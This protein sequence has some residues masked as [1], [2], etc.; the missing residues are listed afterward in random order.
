MPTRKVVVQGTEIQR[1]E[2]SV[3][4]FSALDPGFLTN[5]GGPFV[6]TGHSIAG[7]ATGTLPANCIDILSTAKE[8]PEQFDFL[9]GG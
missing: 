5:P 2:F 8:L 3:R 6:L 4:T 9:I 7:A 1:L